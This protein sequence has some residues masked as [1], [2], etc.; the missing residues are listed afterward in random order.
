MYLELSEEQKKREKKQLASTD[1]LLCV[2]STHLFYMCYCKSGE[3]CK[4]EATDSMR[5]ITVDLA[6]VPHCAYYISA[7]IYI[8]KL[9]VTIM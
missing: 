5:F 4:Q 9:F 2:Y 1:L 7:G 8:L 3:Q 6:V